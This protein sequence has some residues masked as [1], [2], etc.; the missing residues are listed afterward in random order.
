MNEAIYKAMV[1]SQS[2]S[3]KPGKQSASTKYVLL[4]RYEKEEKTRYGQG[5]DIEDEAQ[6][7]RPKDGPVRYSGFSSFL[8]EP[9]ISFRISR[10]FSCN[11]LVSAKS[12]PE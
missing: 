6:G 10:P 9:F 2:G 1:A 7:R 4:M 5:S 12:Q 8:S 11:D 3:L